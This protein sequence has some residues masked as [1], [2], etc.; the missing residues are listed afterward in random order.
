MK[1]TAPPDGSR[2]RDPAM[3][4]GDPGVLRGL[5]AQDAGAASRLTR[6]PTAPHPP[7]APIPSV[8]GLQ[9]PRWEYAVSQAGAAGWELVV[10]AASAYP[11]G[12]ATATLPVTLKRLHWRRR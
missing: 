7:T 9:R 12:Q 4:A 6:A 5:G 3:L 2:R 10:Q 8:T 1:S 11:G